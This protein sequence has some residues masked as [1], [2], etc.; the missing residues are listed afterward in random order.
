MTTSAI[1]PVE[2]RDGQFVPYITAWSA[3]EV[4]PQ[5]VT[6][7]RGRGGTGLGFRDEVS[8]ID[9]QHGVLWLRVPALRRGEPRF[10]TVHALR[11]RHAMR[12]LLCQVCG[13][14]TLSAREDERALFLVAARGDTPI[15]EGEQTASPPVHA[16]CARLAVNYCPPLRRGWAAALVS[17]TPVWGF[18]G[19][20][21]D[22]LTLQP[23][24]APGRTG[25]HRVPDTDERRLRWL[26]AARLIVTLENVT[27]V[28][29][30]DELADQEAEAAYR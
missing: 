3:E 30:L 5:P 18:A 23:L 26:L 1:R 11:Q 15:R 8:H 13:G 9:R 17:S 4:P 27:P 10:D 16:A 22:P 21:Y 2:L 29:D 12:R 19:L 6:V 14:P 7:Q 28:T 20:L 25:L 24:P